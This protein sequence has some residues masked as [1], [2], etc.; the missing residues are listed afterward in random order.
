MSGVAL[1]LSAACGA[2]SPDLAALSESVARYEAGRAALEA[3]EASTAAAA[4]AE[5][6]TSR[7]DD[8]LLTQ[9][10]ARALWRS[11]DVDQAEA[12]LVGLVARH[13]SVMTARYDLGILKL[14]RG[15]PDGANDVRAAVDAGVR[16]AA[17]AARDPD[18]APHLA[19]LPFLSAAP[20]RLVV[21]VDPAPATVGADV[22]VTAEVFGVLDAPWSLETPEAS[23]PVEVVYASETV[24]DDG[25]THRL[26]WVLRANGTGRV[27]LPAMVVRQG[28]AEMRAVGGAYE[29]TS[30]GSASAPAPAPLLAL[31][32]PSQQPVV[33][34][35]H[36]APQGDGWSVTWAA[37][38]RLVVEPASS[39]PVFRTSLRVVDRDGTSLRAEEHARYAAPP[40]RAVVLRG[41]LVEAQ[42]PPDADAR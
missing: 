29:V 11:G 14:N 25:E 41:T 7:P 3:G 24:V 1:A 30:S 42:W 31:P 21:H 40:M 20:L 4:F 19:A 32:I 8:P 6:R 26:S 33:A 5:A 37:D 22:V 12:L 2:P 36:A 28:S 10:H 16:T 9:W 18:L 39:L 13:P 38:T 17:A 27:S 23:G 35:P 15:E 34:L